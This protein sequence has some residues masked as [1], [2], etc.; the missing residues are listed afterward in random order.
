MERR[1]LLSKITVLMK[2]ALVLLFILVTLS[3]KCQ[4]RL[5]SAII[6]DH[7]KTQF[8]GGIGLIS[9][10][11]GYHNKKESIDFTLMLGYL[12]EKYGNGII[13]TFKNNYQFFKID[14]RNN[15][16]I[17]PLGLGYQISYFTGTRYFII[18][19]EYYPKKYYWWAT[20]VRPGAFITGRVDK[21][22]GDYSWIK[23]Y[24]FYY[25][26]GTNELEVVSYIQNTKALN[27]TDIFNL[28]IGVRFGLK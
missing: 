17:R 18:L 25:E 23:N 10:G 22:A 11:A 19:P 1:V 16:T 28:G 9:A 8:A 5:K 14:G 12:P 7:I 6:P 26:L 24:G 21:I 15:L 2:E 3:G 4:S 20:A 27:L 13:L